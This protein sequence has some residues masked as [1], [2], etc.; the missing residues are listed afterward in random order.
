[1]KL[2]V[3]L[4]NPGTQYRDTRHNVGFRFLDLLAQEQHTSFDSNKN[5][6]GEVATCR[7]NNEKISLLKPQTFMNHSGKSVAALARYFDID[8]QDIF[9]IYDDLDL[10]SG[11]L[12]LKKGGGHGGHN[13]L[14]S[15][16]QHLGDHDYARIKLGIGRP[17]HGDVSAWVL[18]KQT[19]EEA[20]HEQAVFQG[21][22]K[23]IGSILD[24]DLAGASNRIH[25]HLN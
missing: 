12:R 4:G 8:V 19:A 2:I 5:F 9:V 13:G 24:D 14:K 6:V 23:E 11:K 25:L 18:G 10:P 3:G 22:L 7:L 17:E 15:L 21:L 20:Q 16:H 1:M